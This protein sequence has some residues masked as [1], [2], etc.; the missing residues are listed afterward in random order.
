MKA[1]LSPLFFQARIMLK[2][3]VIF[4]LIAAG[5]SLLGQVKS[6]EIIKDFGIILAIEEAKQ[7]NPNLEYKI[8]IDLK[9]TISDPEQINAGLNNVARMLNLHAAG[10]IAPENIKV[11]VA[12]HGGA[13]PL[14]LSHEGY[15]AK[16][17]IKN[18][19]LELIKQLREAKVEIFVCGQSLIGRN[20]AFESVNTEIEIA[21]SM[22]TVVTE[23][24]IVGYQL[25]VFQ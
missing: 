24:T 18:P 6:S 14:V 3:K 11:A 15:E 17:G 22:L 2:N 19:N 4:I 8:V 16:Y 12:V 9:T 1:V 25:L 10:G 13:T 23:K 20:Y 7:P 5:H 21:L